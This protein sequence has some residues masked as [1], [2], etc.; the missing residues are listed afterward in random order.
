LVAREAGVRR[1]C[2][3]HH[4][5][6]RSDD[7]LDALVEDV[8]AHAGPDLAVLAAAQGQTLTL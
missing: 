8:R 6:S 5:P 7:Q 2:L 3:F 1:L 4:D